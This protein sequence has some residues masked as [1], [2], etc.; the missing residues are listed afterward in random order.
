MKTKIKNKEV[1]EIISGEPVDFP[2]Y[3]TQLMNLAN[4]NAQG[5]RASV[6]GQMS[7]LIQ[8]FPGRTL[9]EW[10][11]WYTRKHPNAITNASDKIATMVDHLK[12]AIYMIDKDLVEKWVED[13]VILKTFVGLRFQEAILKKLSEVKNE[14]YRLA[15]PDEE[16]KGID[17]YIGSI[18]ISIKPITYKTKNSLSEN[19]EVAIIFYEKKKDGIVVEYDF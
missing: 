17:G 19:I 12:S 7:D 10:R 3:T 13:L 16:S 9:D 14:T 8:E 11:E 4:Q 6:V 1:Q 5:T 15:T 18:P 2:K